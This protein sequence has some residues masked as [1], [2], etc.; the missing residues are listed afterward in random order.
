M[1]SKERSVAVTVKDLFTGETYTQI[2]EISQEDRLTERQKN[3]AQQYKGKEDLMLAAL[4]LDMTKEVHRQA[5]Q[6]AAQLALNANLAKNNNILKDSFDLRISARTR[7][8]DNQLLNS[9]LIES[10]KDKANVEDMYHVLQKVMSS[11][12][13][14]RH[15]DGSITYSN[16]ELGLHVTVDAKTADILNVKTDHGRQ[17]T[18][19]Q[20]RGVKQTVER[21]GY[22]PRKSEELRVVEYHGGVYEKGKKVATTLKQEAKLSGIVLKAGQTIDERDGFVYEFPQ[23]A[24]T[25]NNYSELKK[26]Y[27]PVGIVQYSFDEE[28]GPKATYLE[29][30]NN[31][32]EK[33]APISL[34]QQGPQGRTAQL[35]TTAVYDIHRIDSQ[36]NT[37][38]LSYIKIKEP[39]IFETPKGNIAVD[40]GDRIDPQTGLITNSDL[41][42]VKGAISGETI[43]SVQSIKIKDQEYFVLEN[44]NSSFQT[45][46]RIAGNQVQ[47]THYRT[48]DI[49][50][51]IALGLERTKDY[52]IDRDGFAV[53]GKKKFDDVAT[54]YIEKRSSGGVMR[55]N[56]AADAV[57]DVGMK[58][59]EMPLQPPALNIPV[60]APVSIPINLGKKEILI[61]V[62]EHVF[63]PSKP[64]KIE[65]G[66]EA[67]SIVNG[68]RID[69]Q[70]NIIF[71]AK[72]SQAKAYY[73]PE[74]NT[75]EPIA[76]KVFAQRTT[77]AFADQAGKTTTVSAQERYTYRDG[78]KQQGPII[79]ENDFK[80]TTPSQTVI[81]I[82]KGDFVSGKTL[83]VD[84]RTHE[85]KAVFVDGKIA[86]Y[87]PKNAN[88]IAQ[89]YIDNAIFNDENFI[90][91]SV[92]PLEARV[93]MSQQDARGDVKKALA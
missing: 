88:D 74:K 48:K 43:T 83:I 80:I 7:L 62:V 75:I 53:V 65:F 36:E 30:K 35:S 61:P 68:D 90:P 93:I 6:K 40:A 91:V 67:I 81:P 21:K 73:N 78:Y 37:P 10:D 38:Q 19:A 26:Q 8:A 22:L 59:K 15:A 34:K 18:L 14:A 69:P 56:V 77:I 3:I 4:A 5:K 79:I 17:F 76:G 55:E 51:L 52:T 41:T 25:S 70:T 16:V 82:K 31:V 64:I 50:S 49:D 85:I 20:L 44:G 27:S 12:T 71:S 58:A 32:F 89:K 45:V 42:K 24:L 72:T 66:R 13:K 11:G 54:K 9:I 84:G 1:N 87:D 92:T 86:H 63:T 47:P 33:P 28:K 60:I 2:Q 57:H 39:K 29:I 23:G 46:V